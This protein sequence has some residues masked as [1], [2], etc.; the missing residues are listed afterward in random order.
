MYIGRI[1][2]SSGSSSNYADYTSVKFLH[3]VSTT[4]YTKTVYARVL[5]GTKIWLEIS[6]SSLINLYIKTPD[7]DGTVTFTKSGTGYKMIEVYDGYAICTF[8]YDA[9]SSVVAKGLGEYKAF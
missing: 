4:S 5:P 8:D 6:T 3:I 2:S 9:S 7:R 1:T